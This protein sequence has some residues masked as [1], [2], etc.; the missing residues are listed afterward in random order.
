MLHSTGR[1]R[2]SSSANTS[3][4][5]HRLSGDAQDVK[6]SDIGYV[7]SRSHIPL[8]SR[9]RSETGQTLPLIAVFMLMIIAFAGLVIDIGNVYRVQQALQASTDAAA[10]A[11]AGQLTLQ[12]PPSTSAAV[13][14]A[15]LFS[16]VAGGKNMI[17]GVPS[18][19]V[20]E[21][22]STSCVGSNS[23]LPC[24]NANTIAVSQSATVP[25]YFLR[26]IGFDNI[27][28]SATAKACSPCNEV[29]LDIQL[30]VDRTGSM[31]A[32]G[33][34][35][36]GENKWENLQDGLLQGFLPGLDSGVDNVGLSTLPPDVN[37]TSDVCNVAQNSNYDSTHPTYT[38]VPLSNSYMAPGGSLVT[39]SPLIKDINCMRPGGTTDYAD[40]MEAAYNELQADG[41][42][43]VQKII[44]LLSD[45]AANEGQNCAS[46]TDRHG[47]TI[48][49][50]D[51][52]CMQ[53]CQSAV[54]DAATYKQQGIL[55]YTILYGDQSNGTPCQDYTGDDEVPAISAAQAMKNI[56]TTNN[57]Y[58]DPNPDNL[59]AI[60]QQIASDMAAGTSRIVG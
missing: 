1:L 16:S 17:P 22:I 55:I 23:N 3:A 35:T 40:A 20:N 36:N 6:I 2:R 48:K 45:G 37:G 41:R 39:S 12:Y 30:V 54:N 11:G 19:G 60:F 27:D 38:V 59:V 43:G 57:Y 28:V 51:P 42:A 56:A 5:H 18:S 52:H 13:S 47:N 9:L 53:P 7:D 14:Q 24:T 44:V 34:A 21:S 15:K 25:T 8:A 58:P 29:P 4:E 26:V 31:S 46:T 33:G 50:T 32:N 10:A 49:D